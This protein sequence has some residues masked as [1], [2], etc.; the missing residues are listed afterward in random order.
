MMS[1]ADAKDTAGMDDAS[2]NAGPG[3]APESVPTATP[4][5]QLP[6]STSGG[7]SGAGA[8]T[9]M[10]PSPQPPMTGADT[11]ATQAADANR[12]SE[13]ST[14]PAAGNGAAIEPVPGVTS[15]EPLS[16]PPAEDDGPGAWTLALGVLAAASLGTLAVL[17]ISRRRAR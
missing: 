13:Y 1:G 12:S 7:V 14:E 11:G 15:F 5:P 9:P 3:A 8:E 4:E 10:V 17:E 6:Q 16:A 2:G